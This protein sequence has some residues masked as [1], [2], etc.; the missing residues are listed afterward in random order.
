MTES[1]I[2]YEYRYTFPS[3]VDASRW[4]LAAS[5]DAASELTFFDGQLQ[6]ADLVARMLMVLSQIVR[7]HFFDAR[8]PQLDPIATSSPHRVRWEGFSGCCGVYARVDLDQR[9]FVDARQTFGT[10]NVDFN[11][12]M[13]S[14]LSRVGRA[15][16]VRLSI[17]HD[18]VTLRSDSEATVERKVALPRRWIKGLSEVQVYQTRLRLQ[19]TLRPVVLSRLLQGVRSSPQSVQYLVVQGAAARLS[20]REL[21]GSVPIAGVERLKP[22][23]MLLPHAAEVGLWSDASSQT[24]A[25]SVECE[26]GRFWTVLSPALHRGFSGEGQVLETLACDGARQVADRMYDLLGWQS[27]LHPAEL[28]TKLGCS[29]ADASAALAV[30]STRGIAGFDAATGYYFHRELPFNLEA[31]DADQPRLLGARKLVQQGRVTVVQH[32]ANGHDVEVVGTTAKQFVRL[33]NDG[34][35]CTCV[36]F[37]R[38]Q[39]Q[40]GPCKHILAARMVARETDRRDV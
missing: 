35:R 32:S 3:A 2:D 25:V 10:T 33:R 1:A 37:T 12:A 19:H 27:E 8:P 38:H 39:G 13:L 15:D 5:A 14:H 26:V 18:G 4:E 11:S 29:A 22:L 7:T 23:V 28:A 30:L 34:D 40:R 21:P 17:R 24:S 20:V 6:R 9:A 16:N 36:W 31:I